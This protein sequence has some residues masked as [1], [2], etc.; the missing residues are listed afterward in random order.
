MS[1]SSFVKWATFDFYLVQAQDFKNFLRRD[2]KLMLARWRSQPIRKGLS[3]LQPITERLQ[4]ISLKFR[5]SSNAKMNQCDWVE[6]RVLKMDEMRPLLKL[7]QYKIKL[8]SFFRITDFDIEKNNLWPFIVDAKTQM[9]AKIRNLNQ[10]QVFMR[11]TES[12]WQ[13]VPDLMNN[14]NLGDRII[15]LL[16]LVPVLQPV[17][18]RTCLLTARLSE[19]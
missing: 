12:K 9:S 15:L 2:L 5:L 13:I 14:E 16:W 1:F 7:L 6:F 8:F 10:N 18:Y 4:R 3:N 17:M 11:K 19:P